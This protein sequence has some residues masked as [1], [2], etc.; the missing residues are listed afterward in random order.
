[1][2]QDNDIL[3][4]N[5][6]VPSSGSSKRL[7]W[8][9]L[10][11]GR[12]AKEFAA[13]VGMSR[14]GRL[15][16]VATRSPRNVDDA[17][18]AGA[19]I[20]HSYAALLTD[21]EVQAVYIATPHPTHAE[22]AIKAAEAGKHILCEKPIGMNAADA[23][24]IIDAAKRN[25]VFLMEAFMYRSH[26]QTAKLIEVLRSGLIGDVRLVQ[27]TFGYA[28]PFDPKA[29][30]Y[31][32][33]L[34][35][36]G[37]LDVGCYCTSLARLIAGVS[38]GKA[39]EEPIKVTGS[40]HLGLTGVD[41]WAIATLQFPS[42]LVAQL[43]TSVALPQDNVVRVYGTL[44]S[45]E[46]TSPWF[47]SGRQGGRSTIDVRLTSG[48]THTIPIETPDWLYSIEADVVS[49][50]IGGRQAPWPAPDWQDT[51]GNMRTLDAWRAAIG[52][53]YEVERPGGRRL[54]LSGR[55]LTPPRPGGRMPYD[56]VEHVGKPVSKLAIGCM[57]FTTLPD[58]SVMYDA[59]VEAGG[60][61][62]DS[63]H[64][65]QQGRSDLLLGQWLASRK[66]RDQLV[67]I[68]KG[69]HTPD[70]TPEA[71]TR[72]LDETLER[73][74][75]DYVDIYFLHRDNPDVP[76]GEFVD[77]LDEHRRAGRIRTYGG[78]NWTTARMDEANDYARMSGKQPFGV[79][80]NHYSLAEMIEPMW[81]GC[82]AASDEASEE[83]LRRT[84][85]P[86]FAWSSQARGFFTDR[87]GRG[88]N[89]DPA[90]V[91]TW[92]NETNFGRR[93]RA[94]DL[95]RKHSTT[96]LNIALAYVLAQDL[97]I[98]PII[99]PLTLDELRGSLNALD[100]R[101]TE[102]ELRWLKTGV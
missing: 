10:G 75:T 91:R 54:P 74:G 52:L 84:G 53:E 70:C 50:N 83:W 18:F 1:M 38:A 98:F 88:K 79:L 68:G 62:F 11:T 64:R 43:S 96:L 30:Q 97:P 15:T 42:G 8:G 76:V 36:G 29:R 55:P 71:V 27:A 7:S 80:S 21:P 67:I 69:A 23:M 86:L 22:W 26:P 35:G 72:E 12:I 82:I 49:Q 9:I 40:G 87:A 2:T 59:F 3:A 45:L 66:M 81:P 14:R 51:M 93:D 47:C 41:E 46:L 19:R 5:E 85:T 44:G 58:A 99:G 89:S 102:D 57:G 100:V 17:E 60:N 20:H 37:I 24:A 63:A 61:T 56:I 78:S 31:A 4:A 16:A 13:A 6:E 34:G 25:D 28:K 73:L 48:E 92:Y 32:N 101:L 95:A 77:I 33:E 90:M 39:V 65:Y 94:E